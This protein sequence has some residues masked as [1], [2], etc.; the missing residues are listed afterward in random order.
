MNARRSDLLDISLKPCGTIV[1]ITALIVVIIRILLS[2]PVC[3]AAPAALV[4]T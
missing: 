1:L 2:V 4:D 3:K